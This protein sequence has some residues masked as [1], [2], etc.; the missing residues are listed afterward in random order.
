MT[1]K[2]DNEYRQSDEYKQ[3]MEA[4][5]KENPFIP[6]ALAEY[7][8]I[9]HKTQPD[10]Y[11]KDKQAKEIMKQP[12]KPPKNAGEIVLSDAIQVGNMTPEIE[13]QRD[14][15]WAKHIPKNDTPQIEEVSA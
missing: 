13:K 10:A 4:I 8:I 15:F 3:F 9:A 1:F 5:K 12:I 11:K 6:Q 7:C 2:M 14:E